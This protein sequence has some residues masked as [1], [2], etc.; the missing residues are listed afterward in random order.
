[1]SVEFRKQKK[2]NL[3]EEQN[4]RRRELLK[5]YGKILYK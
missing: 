1:M 4:S 3:V 2:L 5:I